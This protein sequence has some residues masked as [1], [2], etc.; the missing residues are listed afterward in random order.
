MGIFSCNNDLYIVGAAKSLC[1]LTY[2][3]RLKIDVVGLSKFG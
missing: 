3:L 2:F 1:V